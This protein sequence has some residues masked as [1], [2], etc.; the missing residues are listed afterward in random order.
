MNEK[1]DRRRLGRRDPTDDEALA[2]EN[3]QLRGALETRIAIEQ[4]KGVLAERFEISVEEAFGLL[5]FGARS[6]RVPIQVVAREVRPAAVT[7]TAVVDAIARSPHWRRLALAHPS[8][9]ARARAAQLV[10][11]VQRVLSERDTTKPTTRRETRR[12]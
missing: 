3:Q 1:C 7:P 10:D 5:R 2:V 12:R 9:A 8:D 6:A 4:A 11:Q